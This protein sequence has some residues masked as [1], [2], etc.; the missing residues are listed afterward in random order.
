MRTHKNLKIRLENGE[1][2]FVPAGT[3]IK[4]IKVFAGQGTNQ[5][6]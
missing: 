3:E 6:I 2:I 5:E 1:H 4:K